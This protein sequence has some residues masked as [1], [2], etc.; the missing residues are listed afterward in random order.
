[1]NLW[2]IFV[3]T[4]LPVD[5]LCLSDGCIVF[6]PKTNSVIVDG[7]VIFDAK[8]FSINSI[9]YAYGAPINYKEIPEM[10]EW[11]KAQNLPTP[12]FKRSF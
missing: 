5:L 1:M 12:Q 10:L 4:H 2:Q 6:M 11:L 3:Q 9:E 7:D 8:G